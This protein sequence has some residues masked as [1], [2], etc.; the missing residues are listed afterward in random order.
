LIGYLVSYWLTPIVIQL[1]GK[2][3]FMDEPGERRI[4]ETPVPRAGGIAVFCGFHAACA[5]VFFLPWN[6]SSGVI[7]T[8]WWYTYL[9]VSG[10]LLIVGLIDD[11]REL[12]PLIK[13]AGQ[14]AAATLM[15][16][17]EVRVGGLFGFSF[18]PVLDYVATLF[19]F[20]FIINAFNLIDGFDGVCAGLAAIASLGICGSFMFRFMPL[21]A[22]IMWGL[23]GACIGFLRY[24][25]NPAQIFLGDSGSM[26]LGLTL[27]SVT[28]STASKGTGLAAIWVPLLALGIPMFDTFLAVWRRGARRVYDHLRRNKGSGGIMSADMDHLHHRLMQVGLT[29]RNVTAS[30]YLANSLLVLVGLSSLIY[31]SRALGIFA[32]AFV[33]GA[34]VVIR[35]VVKIELWNSG[36]VIVHGLG[37]GNKTLLKFMAYAGLDILGLAGALLVAM[38]VADP[39]RS[40][41]AIFADWIL[42]VPVWCGIPFLGLLSM[43]TYQWAWVG[44]FAANSTRRLFRVVAGLGLVLGMVT[45]ISTDSAVTLAFQGV[46]FL[47][48][49]LAYLRFVRVFPET[50]ENMMAKRTRGHE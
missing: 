20:L 11:L 34:Y 42:F 47:V 24:N 18:S 25:F 40:L 19:W 21:E 48:L 36:L 31:R 9:L 10:L 46:I 1:S 7:D 17:A 33:V 15:F 5:V 4:H 35:Y 3:G 26:F 37:K 22:L 43:D 8:S 41:H 29:P 38:W 13:L 45:L 44:V 32:V 50:V 2:A 16:L 12:R 49:S 14:I 39:S 23:I 27:A 28:L 6:L 30:L